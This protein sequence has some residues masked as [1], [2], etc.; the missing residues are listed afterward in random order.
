MRSA[1]LNRRYEMEFFPCRPTTPI[2]ALPCATNIVTELAAKAY[3]RAPSGDDVG[4]L[5]QFY[6]LG[7]ENGGFEM[8]IR[9]ALE[10]VLA[11]PHFLFRMEQEPSRVKP[12][13]TYSL[14]D[15]DLARRLSL[16]LWGTNPDDEL[17]ALAASGKLSRTR[18]LRAQTK[19]MLADPRSEALSTRF[20]SLWL[21]L[22]DLEH[23]QPDSFWFPNYSQQLMQAMRRET[24]LFFYDL[25][26]QDKSILELYGANYSFMNERL[27]NHYGIPGVIGDEFRRVKIPGHATERNFWAR[28][29]LSADIV[30]QSNVTCST[31]KMGRA[32]F[33]RHSTPTPTSRSS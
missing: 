30:R 27:A 20:A 32:S 33:T 29:Y 7:V 24:E 6:T 23:V 9:T 1:S 28:Q 19:R 16:F 3:G 18:T 13:D 17:L 4:D 25:V 8:G 15:I 10:A 21:R 26:Q 2:E 11:S 22:Q 31:R 5:M 12:G 14:A